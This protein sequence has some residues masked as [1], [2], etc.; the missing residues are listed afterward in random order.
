MSHAHSAVFGALAVVAVAAPSVALAQRGVAPLLVAS[1]DG[2]RQSRT[3]HISFLLP[4]GRWK[5]P[6]NDLGHVEHGFY[7]R[8]TLV[9]GRQCTVNLSVGGR[10]YA[11]RPALR[12]IRGSDHVHRG[13]RDG[14]T[15]LTAWD[16][17]PPTPP[18][19]YA[20][21]YRHSPTWAARPW[22]SF[23]LD[24]GLGEPA[25][26]ACRRTLRELA[27]AATARSFRVERGGIG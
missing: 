6:T 14:V 23:E 16:E 17:L 20:M 10:E 5:Q 27:L 15:W 4:A 21:A 8:T 13:D 7:T 12:L 2:L 9:G 18:E 1:H 25:T 26:S 11:H 24:P 22:T 19:P 3:Q